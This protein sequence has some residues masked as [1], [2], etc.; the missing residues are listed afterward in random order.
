M[1]LYQLKEYE[2]GLFD[3]QDEGSQYLASKVDIKVT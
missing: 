3:I 1:S 2:Q